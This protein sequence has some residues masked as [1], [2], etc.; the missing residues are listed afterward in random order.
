LPA[1]SV[2]DLAMARYGAGDDAAF[3]DVYDVVAPP[4]E[5]YLLKHSRDRA[6]SED[7]LQQTFLKMH[8][9]RGAFLPG[10]AVMPWA[11]A[12]ALRLLIDRIRRRRREARVIADTSI[13][14][15]QAMGH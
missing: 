6:L 2:A 1:P 10:S 8:R 7:L 12:I 14:D 15:V 11:F 5:R 3:A 13:D 9:H 4:L